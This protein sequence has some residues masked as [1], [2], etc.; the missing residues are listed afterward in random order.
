MP[1]EANKRYHDI[2]DI[3]P[4]EIT[5]CYRL[6]ATRSLLTTHA[7]CFRD[8]EDCGVNRIV[9]REREAWDSIK[10]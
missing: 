6:L 3:Y 2:V 9:L 4:N 1:L 10:Q 5:I 7:L 8:Q